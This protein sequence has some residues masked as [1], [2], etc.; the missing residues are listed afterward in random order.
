MQHATQENI[1]F[2]WI[3]CW[4]FM[5]RPIDTLVNEK[6]PETTTTIWWRVF[7]HWSKL[8]MAECLLILKYE[9]YIVYI[10][11]MGLES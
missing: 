1:I 3:Y 8:K 7:P 6:A 11:Q 9:A 5:C 10:W 2:R 4:R